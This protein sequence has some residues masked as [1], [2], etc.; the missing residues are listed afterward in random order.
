MDDSFVSLL[1]LVLDCS[2]IPLADSASG[3]RKDGAFFSDKFFFFRIF[4]VIFV[5]SIMVCMWLG[6]RSVQFFFPNF[7]YYFRNNG[8]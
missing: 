8:R 6:F 7:L 4:L 5:G 2:F 1:T 3:T